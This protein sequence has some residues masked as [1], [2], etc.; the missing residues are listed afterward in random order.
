[1][2]NVAYSCTNENTTFELRE[3]NIFFPVIMTTDFVTQVSED[4]QYQVI[5]KAQSQV[6]KRVHKI[7]FLSVR[8]EH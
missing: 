5:R 6:E 3:T 7:T 4:A 2:V 8:I 1:M